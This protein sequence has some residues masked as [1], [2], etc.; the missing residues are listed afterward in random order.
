MFFIHFFLNYVSH[1]IIAYT[2]NI[3][4][5]LCFARE[6][7]AIFFLFIIFLKF[8]C[9]LA[10]WFLAIGFSP[11]QRRGRGV[12]S[13]GRQELESLQKILD[14]QGR[15]R[16]SGLPLSRRTT[17]S[18]STSRGSLQLLRF[19]A[20]LLE[21]DRDALD[22]GCR[23]SVFLRTVARGRERNFIDGEKKIV[24]INT[25]YKYW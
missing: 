4:A 24:T 15:G 23:T 6:D 19:V 12:D 22:P 10:G 17:I 5:F 11:D 13:S 16:Y 20:V 8:L 3:H 2:K 1:E 14:Q 21:M 9:G 25:V 18:N 7:V